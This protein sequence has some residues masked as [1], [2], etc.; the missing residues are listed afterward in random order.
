MKEFDQKQ[1]ERAAI[2]E[3]GK[4]METELNGLLKDKIKAI[5]SEFEELEV[6][7]KMSTLVDRIAKSYS[8]HF[9]DCIVIADAGQAQAPDE[10]ELKSFFESVLS[11]KLDYIAH[12]YGKAS[13]YKNA[14]QVLSQ[15]YVPD[16]FGL[17]LCNVGVVD[18]E[19]LE[20]RLFPSLAEEV[21]VD[22]DLVDSVSRKL[23]RLKVSGIIPN[24]HTVAL[25]TTGNLNVMTLLHV[26]DE[27]FSRVK[28][29]HPAEVLMG[30]LF[31]NVV[32][33][34]IHE[35][36]WRISY[37]GYETIMRVIS[38]NIMQGRM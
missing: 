17:F 20:V 31:E 3:N 35:Q 11:L 29:L 23:K 36:M 32:N 22:F 10:N 18:V 38:D 9:E 1:L 28:D 13:K 15:T 37:G 26:E 4:T 25:S 7:F 16:F 6:K 5:S 33:D 19:D 2:A 12:K 27:I 14:S 24:V 30:G 34:Y 21:V 8:S